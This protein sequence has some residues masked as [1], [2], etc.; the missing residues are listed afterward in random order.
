LTQDEQNKKNWEQAQKKYDDRI[1]NWI[2]RGPIKNHIRVLLCTLQDILW[3]NSGW[4][5]V[6]MDKL[7]D[8]SS[9]RKSYLKAANICHPDKI[10][11][12][13]DPDKLYIANR[14]FA[15]L[16]EAFNQYK[17]YYL[18]IILALYNLIFVER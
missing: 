18:L 11:K 3:P 8:F 17:V 4:T 5:R 2:G 7:M 14:C 13:D 9:V 10:Q 1:N 15:A 12:N 6:G 16:T